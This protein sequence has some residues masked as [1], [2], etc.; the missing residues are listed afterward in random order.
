[1]LMKKK[2][3]QASQA[4]RMAAN[5]VQRSN[6]WIGDFFRRMKAKGG[7]RYA[8]VATANKIATSYYKMVSGKQEFN[9]LDLQ[10]YLEKRK[11][12][13]IRSEVT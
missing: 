3:N 4:F 5:P 6:N 11:S 12:A 1:M 7:N 2:P 10:Q 13:K 9:S 8:I